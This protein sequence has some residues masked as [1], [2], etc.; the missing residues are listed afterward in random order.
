MPVI[1]QHIHTVWTKKSRGGE[2]ARVRNAIPKA[3]LLPTDFNSAPFMLHHAV[4]SEFSNFSQTDERKSA[5]GFEQLNIRDMEISPTEDQLKIRLLRD[6]YNAA[7]IS[8][9]PFAD[10]FE[11]SLGEWGQLT[12][13]GRYICRSTGN[14]WYEQS[15]YNIGRVEKLDPRLFV[16]IRPDHSYSELAKLR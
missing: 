6:G 9:Y 12:Y 11:L 5:V 4:F 7:K 14:W 8:P 10:V 1:I 16:S 3:M 2:G 13:N 15:T